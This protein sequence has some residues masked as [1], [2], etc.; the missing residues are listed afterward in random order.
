MT[1]CQLRIAV[2]IVNIWNEDGRH[3][4]MGR[5]LLRL[6]TRADNFVVKGIACVDITGDALVRA[7][8]AGLVPLLSS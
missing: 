6:L 7:L 8:V 1:E 2:C 5:K 3:I 4:Y